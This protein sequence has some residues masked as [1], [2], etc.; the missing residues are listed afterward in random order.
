M[1]MVYL[2]T[3]K[4]IMLVVQMLEVGSL[5]NDGSQTVKVP[6]IK[7]HLNVDQYTLHGSYGYQ[8]LW[9]RK[10][11]RYVIESSTPISVAG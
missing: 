4:S 3:Y 10:S 2:Y 8:I 9:E 7:N 6:N 11:H 5:N 1:Y